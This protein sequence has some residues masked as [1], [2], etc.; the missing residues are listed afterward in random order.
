MLLI[1]H[2]KQLDALP[3]SPLK[4]YITTRY[5]DLVETEDDIPP[6]FVIVEEDDDITGPD[7]AFVSCNGLLG[8]G[9]MNTPQYINPFEKIVHLTDI[10]MYQLL[11]LVS[12]EDGYWIYIS[13]SIVEAHPDLKWVLTD[14]SQGGLSA[15][16]PL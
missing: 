16:Q 6:I 2:R 3:P 7:F 15:P 1:T 4:N 11:Y 10:N 13:N 14:D 9:E 5:Q 8:E 12:G